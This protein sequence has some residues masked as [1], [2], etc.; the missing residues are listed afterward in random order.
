MSHHYITLF[1][2]RTGK[3]VHMALAKKEKKERKIRGH[4]ID[5]FNGT[6]NLDKYKKERRSDIFFH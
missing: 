4:A 5:L 3:Y 2:N 1:N 6:R